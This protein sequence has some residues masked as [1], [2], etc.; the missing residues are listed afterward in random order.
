MNITT[1]AARCP[2]C[3]QFHLIASIDAYN[4]RKEVREDFA[5]LLVDNFDIVEVTTDEAKANFG[6]CDTVAN[7]PSPSA[8]ISIF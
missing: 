7:A 4:S 5:E 6:Y 3:G 8:Q 2:E 1:K